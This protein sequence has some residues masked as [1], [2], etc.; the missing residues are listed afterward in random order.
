M[1]SINKFCK[2]ALTLFVLVAAFSCDDLLETEPSVN[3]ITREE[4]LSDASLVRLAVNG[5]YTQNLLVNWAYRSDLTLYVG[6]AADE[7]YHSYTAYDDSRNNTYTPTYAYTEYIYQYLY[8]SVFYANDIIELVADAAD[9][10]LISEDE[11]R[12][13]AAEAKYFR[14]YSYFVLT[15]L[16]GDVPLI[17]STDIV[18]TSLQ[19]RELRS[20]VIALV[21]DD[22]Q[23][24]AAALADRT[25]VDKV[26]ATAA[27]ALLARQHLY[28]GDYASAE[29]LAS[30]VI[31]TPGFALEDDL[32]RVFVRSST[33]TLF[34]TSTDGTW[35]SSS[36]WNR[37]FIGYYAT[38]TN[39]ARTAYYLRLT[40]DLVRSFEPDDRRAVQ[41]LIDRGSF[42]QSY[43]YKRIAATSS[44]E[45][46]DHVHLRLAEQ[47]LIRAEARAQ[48]NRITGADGAIEDLNRIRTR[49]GLADLPQTLSRAETLLAVENERR[50]EL[51]VEEVHRW[52]DLV[53]TGR[54]DAVLGNTALFPD[55]RWAS[56][57]ALLPIPASDIEN[58]PNLTQNPGYGSV[59]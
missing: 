52:W 4:I 9:A 43:K 38:Y 32:D 10:G 25:D 30:E 23:E 22:L 16:W 13:A 49:A 31:A 37:T 34:K 46:E 19:P 12:R 35:S 21:I 54:A 8:Q 20:K 33:E 50:H 57:K 40:D 41:W 45:A 56:Y 17:L 44:G 51:F 29:R 55:K 39:A 14:A 11:R 27:R 24:V 53:R 47:Y 42:S 26:N 6:P 48:Q 7:A 28:A 1:K 18:K 36:Y 58:N 15:A 5:L 3:Q 2:T 59:E